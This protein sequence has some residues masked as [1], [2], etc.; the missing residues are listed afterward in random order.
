MMLNFSGRWSASA[1]SASNPYKVHDAQLDALAAQAGTATPAQATALYGQ[2]ETRVTE[3]AW[4]LSIAD[5]DLVTIARPGLTGFEPNS[6]Y[7]DP[8]PIFFQAG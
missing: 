4:E 5:V 7:L 8:D 1:Q 6:E 2:M 3:L